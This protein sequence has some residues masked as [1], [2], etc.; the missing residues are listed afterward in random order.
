MF[1]CIANFVYRRLKVLLALI[2]VSLIA[3]TFIS[4]GDDEDPKKFDV[5]L[6]GTQ[7][8]VPT[9]WLNGDP[10]PLSSG[11]G[12]LVGGAVLG[13]DIYAAGVEG[14]KA[15]Y[16]KNGSVI[17]LTNGTTPVSVLAMTVS[18]LDVYVAGLENSTAK[19]WKN[20]Q[21]TLL[22]VNV[23]DVLATGVSDIE[24]VN[25]D[26]HVVGFVSKADSVLAVYWKNGIVQSILREGKYNYM[27]VIKVVGPDI[28]ILGSVNNA[29]NIRVLKRWKNGVEATLTD[30]LTDAYSTD[31]DVQGE[32]VYISGVS[33]GIAVYWKNSEVYPLTELSVERSAEAVAIQVVSGAVFV[34]G[35]LIDNNNVRIG[36]TLWRDGKL[37]GPFI[38]NATGMRISAMI[39][40]ER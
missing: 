40:T 1:F 12:Y 21:E 36:G 39:I 17:P 23:A 5:Y 10:T 35:N 34:A 30:G 9:Y 8:N 22:P 24:V 7:Y 20:Q 31:M 16:W 18:G 2:A 14:N 38:G 25:S 26:V 37:Q 6:F 13:D 29:N 27:H 3:F 15:V 4:C 28:Y 19:Y 32:D 11:N 33:S